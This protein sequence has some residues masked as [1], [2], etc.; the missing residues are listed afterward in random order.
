MVI[1][2][3][4]PLGVRFVRTTP[5]PLSF[6]FCCR[7]DGKHTAELSYD[8]IQKKV[9][10]KRITLV[11]S[12]PHIHSMVKARKMTDLSHWLLLSGSVTYPAA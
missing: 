2:R 7:E 3:G 10:L 4:T 9:L 5:P 11:T 8:T 12:Q 1:L 6:F